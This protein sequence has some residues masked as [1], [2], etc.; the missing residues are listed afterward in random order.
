[1]S[2]QMQAAQTL[3]DQAY[4][5]WVLV[6][7]TMVSELNIELPSPENPQE[8]LDA[9]TVL[10]NQVLTDE[11]NKNTAMA[12]AEQV[13]NEKLALLSEANE[14]LRESKS[15]VD[16]LHLSW[17]ESVN[18]MSGVL[19]GLSEDAGYFSAQIA[20]MKT[21]ATALNLGTAETAEIEGIYNALL[22]ALG[23]WKAK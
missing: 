19:S 10:L 6:Y 2:S 21:S 16:A 12:D 15:V 3:Y 18:S 4:S 1:Q 13:W 23:D 20:Q 11:Q 14:K 9:L 17:K 5:E 7:E 8:V 22:L